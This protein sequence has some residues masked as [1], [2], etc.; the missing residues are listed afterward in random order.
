MKSIQMVDLYNQYLA[1]KDEIDIAIEKV[2]KSTQ[3]IKGAE[4]G[5]FENELAKYLNVSN[6]VSCANGT[7]ALMLSLMALELHAGD[8]VIVPSFTFISTAE[9]VSLLGL[10]PVFADIYPG[11]FNIEV[12]NLEKLITSH[13][14]AIIPVHLFGQCADMER[15]MDIAEKHNLY[16]IEDTAQSLGANC[17]FREKIQKAGTIGHLG[18]T[19]FFPSKNLGCFGDGGAVITNDSNLAGKIRLLANHGSEKKYYHLN[20]GMNS[21]LDTLQAAILRIKLKY[22]EHYISQRREA[23]IL[24][25]QYLQDI[26]QIELPEIHNFH[27]FNQYTLTL[28][29]DQRDNLQNYLK[30][31]AVPTA[32]Y[33]PIPLH[34]QPAFQYLNYSKGSLPVAENKSKHVLSLPMHT[35]LDIEQIEYIA[36]CIQSFFSAN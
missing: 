25:N 1:I 21:R 10:V 36:G 20:I 14:R 35:E 15:I 28:K 12:E 31:R 6:V 3:F 22:L 29:N 33:Y 34:M 18:A 24:Y 4:V 30:S 2:I 5:L 11:T 27:T 32:I 23:A 19:S 16:V 17:Q 13:T 7:D 26:S 9:V 8:E